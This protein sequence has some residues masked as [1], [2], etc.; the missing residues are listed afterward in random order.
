MDKRLLRLERERFTS[1]EHYRMVAEH[2]ARKQRMS[3]V[4]GNL[5]VVT[6][7]AREWQ[8]NNP[9]WKT[10]TRRANKKLVQHRVQDK[11]VSRLLT[12]D[13]QLAVALRSLDRRNNE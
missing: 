10:I 9:T 12:P 13:E 1:I 7:E 5:D 4:C 6:R 2:Y 8:K 3:E 11:V